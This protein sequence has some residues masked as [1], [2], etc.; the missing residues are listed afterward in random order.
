MTPL[1]DVG[2]NI[3]RF[4]RLLGPQASWMLGVVRHATAGS[5]NDGHALVAGL[6]Q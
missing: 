4:R 5:V 2:R 1:V 6:L 3:A